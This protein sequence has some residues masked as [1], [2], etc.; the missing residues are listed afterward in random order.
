MLNSE[1]LAWKVSPFRRTSPLPD[2]HCVKLVH[3]ITEKY[4]TPGRA[5]FNFV[6]TGD[7]SPVGPMLSPIDNVKVEK[8]VP[9]GSGPFLYN[10]TVIRL[11]TLVPHI[12]K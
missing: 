2:E 9:S 5:F 7:C 3:G 1:I 10:F 8:K 4:R 12:N 11:F 6:T